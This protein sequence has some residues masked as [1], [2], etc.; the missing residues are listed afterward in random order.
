M[1]NSTVNIIHYHENT[2]V[3]HL[4]VL[5]ATQKFDN[6][7][8]EEACHLGSLPHHPTLQQLGCCASYQ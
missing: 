2:L 1:H 8:K 3:N 4:L 5:C 6:C 7:R